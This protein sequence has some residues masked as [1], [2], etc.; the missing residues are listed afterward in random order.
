MTDPTLARI[1]AD[2]YAKG[3][4]IE[5]P[6]FYCKTATILPIGYVDAKPIKIDMS[7]PLRGL[8]TLDCTVAIIA[9]LR[10]K[11]MK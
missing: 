11:E 9:D 10:K 6:G 4:F 3:Y 5:Y 7:D 8:Q 1:R 2:A